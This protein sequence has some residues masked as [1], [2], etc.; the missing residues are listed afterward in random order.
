MTGDVNFSN[1]QVIPFVIARQMLLS[2]EAKVDLTCSHT[3]NCL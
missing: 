1:I 3:V 2:E